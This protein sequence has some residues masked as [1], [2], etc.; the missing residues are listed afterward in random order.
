MSKQATDSRSVKIEED[1]ASDRVLTV[2]NVISFARLCLVPLYLVLLLNGHDLAATFVFALAASTDWV[3]GQ[4]ARRTHA[5][6]KLGRLLDPAVDRILMIA[7]VVGLLLVGRLPLWIIV[8]VV[9]RDLLLISGAAWLLNRY[10]IRV[11]VVY[12]G[13]FATTFLFIGFA[14]LLLNWPLVQG[15]GL[16]D[17]AWLPGFNGDAVSWSIWFVYAGLVLAIATTVYYV[18][19]AWKKLCAAKAEPLAE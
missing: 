11:A 5:V 16:V 8:V 2:P 7:G 15:L 17:A 6:S 3:D 9:L 1:E 13:K 4:V 19:A 12:P 10:R 14:G 18:S